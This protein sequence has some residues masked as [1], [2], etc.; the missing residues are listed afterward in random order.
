MAQVTRNWE[1]GREQGYF[2]GPES[3][4][5]AMTDETATDAFKADSVSITGTKVDEIR[6]DNHAGRSPL[7]TV[8][9]AKGPWAVEIKRKFIPSGTAG[10]ADDLDPL[11]DAMYTKSTTT[12][13]TTATCSTTG[14]TTVTSG[15]VALYDLLFIPNPTAGQPGQVVRV[16][17]LTDD[18][19]SGADTIIGWVPTLPFTPAAATAVGAMLQYAARDLVTASKYTTVTKRYSAGIEKVAG[20]YPSEYSLVVARGARAEE[21]FKGSGAHHV[22]IAQTTLN[23]GVD[24]ATTSWVVDDSLPYDGIDAT[25]TMRITA[26]AEGVNTEETVIVTAVDHDT[27][28]L[29]VTRSGAPSAHGTGAEIVPYFVSETTTGSQVAGVRGSLYIEGSTRLSIEGAT[30]ND[31][32]HFDAVEEYGDD[33]ITAHVTSAPREISGT[34]TCTGAAGDWQLFG[35]AIQLSKPSVLLQAGDEKG[36]V[37]GVYLQQVKL[38]NFAIPDGA[39]ERIKMEVPFDNALA[40]ATADAMRIAIG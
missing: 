20:F 1:L 21:T 26:L 35:T 24:N 30:I 15:A 8:A 37:I 40:S 3:G 28:T 7:E 22:S 10:L 38:T 34:L 36:K 17:T 27:D 11:R 18:G 33:E 13:F 14:C 5:T 9:G 32:E 12:G 25:H 16:E 29:T 31:N 19:V 2:V 23:G 39:G 6:D 4:F